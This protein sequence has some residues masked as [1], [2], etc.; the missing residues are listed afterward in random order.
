MLK[1]GLT[2][3]C[4]L[5]LV[6][7]ITVTIAVIMGNSQLVQMLTLWLIS[8]LLVIFLIIIIGFFIWIPII[9]WRKE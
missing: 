5:I 3:F 4:G 1:I 2:L 6:W 9:L 8:T 7:L